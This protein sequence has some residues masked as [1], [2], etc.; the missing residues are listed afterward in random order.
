MGATKK[1]LN[2][3]SDIRKSLHSLRED[4]RSI[5]SLAKLVRR[6]IP[7][8]ISVPASPPLPVIKTPTRK[9]SKSRMLATL[10]LGSKRKGRNGSL[11]AHKS[12]HH[13]PRTVKALIM[14]TTVP[15]PP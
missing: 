7:D 11:G 12:D 8:R 1:L 5:E 13:Q 3:F 9:P 10:Q 14:Q 2:T 6:H 4:N 15:V